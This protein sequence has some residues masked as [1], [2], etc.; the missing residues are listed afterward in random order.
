MYVIHHPGVGKPTQNVLIQNVIK[1]NTEVKP[2]N[3]FEYM[4]TFNN[5]GWQAGDSKPP[6]CRWAQLSATEPTLY[7]SIHAQWSWSS[8]PPWC[9]P[10]GS[11]LTYIQQNPPLLSCCTDSRGGSGPG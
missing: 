6:A 1:K 9:D 5:Q 11:T 4:N 7:F 2:Y 3:S 8:C 10:G